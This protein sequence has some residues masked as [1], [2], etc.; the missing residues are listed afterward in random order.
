[1]ANVRLPPMGERILRRVVQLITIAVV[2]L[3]VLVGLFFVSRWWQTT[4]RIDQDGG[5][6]PTWLPSG[7][8]DLHL[9]GTLSSSV[10]SGRCSQTVIEAWASQSGIPLTK[11][12]RG[13]ILVVDYGKVPLTWTSRS[14]FND[15]SIRTYIED[16]EEVVWER[17]TNNGG[18]ITLIYIPSLQVFH[19]NRAQW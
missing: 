3:V 7:V 6:A 14:S 9:R 2:G 5:P 19:G 11:R 17:R 4:V 10:F 1:M 15:E 16:A 12:S 8:E 13:R 18:G